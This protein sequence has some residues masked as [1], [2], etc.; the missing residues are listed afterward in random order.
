MISLRGLSKRY[1]AGSPSTTSAGLRV[2]RT[3]E[4]DLVA[5]GATIERIGDLAFDA[6]VRLHELARRPACSTTA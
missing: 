2:E 3:G 6:G 4:N 1:G 5:S